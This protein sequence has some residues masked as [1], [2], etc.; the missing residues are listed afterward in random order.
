VD[1]VQC[2][3]VA[4][5]GF[6]PLL[7]VAVPPSGTRGEG[8]TPCYLASK[9]VRGDY[10]RWLEAMRLGGGANPPLGRAR[11]GPFQGGRPAPQTLAGWC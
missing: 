2:R 10:G 1:V 9:G 5:A 6:A 11:S 7:I 8:K 3:P 4:D